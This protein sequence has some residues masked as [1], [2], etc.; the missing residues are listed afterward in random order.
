MPSQWLR[1]GTTAPSPPALAARGGWRR[2]N[3]VHGGGGFGPPERRSQPGAAT[4]PAT[5]VQGGA[6]AFALTA[7]RRRRPFA[8]SARCTRRVAEGTSFFL[9]LC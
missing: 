9:I 4:I 7:R 5:R 2:D 6:R 8:T 3:L 1:G